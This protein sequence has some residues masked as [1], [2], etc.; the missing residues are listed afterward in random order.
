MSDA[1]V[2]VADRYRLDGR[3]GSGGAGEV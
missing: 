1:S 2:V 3:I